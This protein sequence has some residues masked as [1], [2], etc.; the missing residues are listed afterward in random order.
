MTRRRVCSSAKTPYW[1]EKKAWDDGLQGRQTPDEVRAVS[2]DHR[3]RRTS[4]HRVV[5]LVSSECRMKYLTFMYN[6]S[7]KMLPGQ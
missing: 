4:K 5:T 6:I 7:L 1:S 2:S 3:D